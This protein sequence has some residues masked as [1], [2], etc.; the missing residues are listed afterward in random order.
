[1]LVLRDDGK[2]FGEAHSGR[3]LAPYT[4]C[5]ASSGWTATGLS[6]KSCRHDD[7]MLNLAP[8]QCIVQCLMVAVIE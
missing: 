1:M 6:S 2:S 4:S 7:T 3:V 8:S 5:S